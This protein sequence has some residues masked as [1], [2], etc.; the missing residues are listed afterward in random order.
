V[1]VC[2]VSPLTPLHSVAPGV[3][4]ASHWPTVT[5]PHCPFE[6]QG[7]AP[8]HGG[9]E[10]PGVQIALHI[11]AVTEPLTHCSALPQVCGTA[12]L[13]WVAPGVQGTQLPS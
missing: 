12:P 7:I 9:G 4:T 11:P 5:A 8:L 1:Q 3:Q 10:A 2:N 13:H 6:L